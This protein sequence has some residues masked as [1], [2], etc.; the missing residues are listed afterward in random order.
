[1]GG[2][3]SRPWWVAGVL[4]LLVFLIR[5]NLDFSPVDE[6]YLWSGVDSVLRGKTPLLDFRSYDPGRYYWC[7]AFAKLFGPGLLS[8]RAACSVLQFLGLWWLL[9]SARFLKNGY[10]IWMF[11]LLAAC[12]MYP[13]FKIATFNQ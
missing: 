2:W 11:G 1:M 7:A 4:S 9:R 6:G 10:G 3:G 8:L 5:W 13:Y 12:W